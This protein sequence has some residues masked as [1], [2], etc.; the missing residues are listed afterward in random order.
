MTDGG[1]K[2]IL[3]DDCVR[4]VPTRRGAALGLEGS[5]FP[6]LTPARRARHSAI[7]NWVPSNVSGMSAKIV[8]IW[9]GESTEMRRDS[10]LRNM[11]RSM[12]MVWARLINWRGL[13]SH[14]VMVKYPLLTSVSNRA[15]S[16]DICG[17][18]RQK[19]ATSRGGSR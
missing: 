3:L 10:E 1:G 6:L 7:W 13:V 8:C 14:I 4:A 12:W 16:P 11:G 19:N 2:S 15:P 5:V 18:R 17:F 9:A